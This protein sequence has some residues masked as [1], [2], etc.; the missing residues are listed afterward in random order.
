MCEQLMNNDAQ[1]RLILTSVPNK[2]ACSCLL[3][4]KNAFRILFVS[5]LSLKSQVSI[6]FL[7]FFVFLQKNIII[8]LKQYQFCAIVLF[9]NC[10]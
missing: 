9:S 3:A 1:T 4:S 8:P 7:I 5:G 2:T 10:K 6:L